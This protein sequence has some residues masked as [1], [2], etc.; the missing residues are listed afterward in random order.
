MDD[1][2]GPERESIMFLD[3]VNPQHS[4][5]RKSSKWLCSLLDSRVRPELVENF[6]FDAVFTASSISWD[7]T[8]AAAIPMIMYF[9]RITHDQPE[10]LWPHSIILSLRVCVIPVY[11]SMWQK[12]RHFEH[13]PACLGQLV[14]PRLPKAY[15]ENLVDNTISRWAACGFCFDRSMTGKLANRYSGKLMSFLIFRMSIFDFRCFD[16]HLFDV[17]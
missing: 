13:C 2:Q 12:T 11:T 16:F 9:C 15:K 3:L 6:D 10:H 7:R 4:P 14:D 17:C 5:I 8:S 1:V